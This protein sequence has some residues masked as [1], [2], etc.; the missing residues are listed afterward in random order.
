MDSLIKNIDLGMFALLVNFPL[1]LATS[2]LAITS[3][4]IGGELFKAGRIIGVPMTIVSNLFLLHN[5]TL[6]HVGSSYPFFPWIL[7]VIAMVASLLLTNHS[8]QMNWD[9]YLEKN[10]MSMRD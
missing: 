7:I 1:I 8:F 9:K 10:P 4:I 6:Q 2:Y 5:M 3:L